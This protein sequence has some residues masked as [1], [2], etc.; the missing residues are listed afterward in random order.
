VDERIQ[1]FKAKCEK[2]QEMLEVIQNLM[3]IQILA[4]EVEH[5]P[6]SY[7][8]LLHSQNEFGVGNKVVYSGDTRPCQNLINYAQGASLLIHEATLESGM[9]EDALKK[10]HTTTKE[11]MEIIRKVKPWRTIL[12]HFSCRY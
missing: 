11:A 9:E 7:G 12:T 10:K 5:C 8:C 1:N 3:D 6:Q 4:I 2:S